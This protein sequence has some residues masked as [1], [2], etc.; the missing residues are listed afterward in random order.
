M[1]IGIDMGTTRTIAAGVD[2]GN[3]PV[4]PFTDPDGD[5]HSHFPSVIA[6]ADGQLVHGFEAERA[7]RAGAPHL[8]SFKRLLGD[9]DTHPGTT[10]RLG[11][12]EHLLLDLVTAYLT[13]VREALPVPVGQVAASV[14]AHA[15]SAQRIMTLE[16]FR[17]AGIDV[18]AL[19]NEPSAAG[20]EYTHHQSR[21][22]TARRTRIAVYD[23]GGGTFDSSLVEADG[24][25]HTVL[26]S[27]GVNRLGG[28]DLDQVLLELVLERAGLT[29]EELGAPAVDALREEC[30]AAKERLLPQT[31][32]MMIDLGEEHD[33][34]I[35]P[36]EDFYAAVAPL[37]ERTLEV[38]ARWWASSMRSPASPGSISSAAGP[39]CRWWDGCCASASAAACTAPRTRR[40]PPRSASRSPRTQTPGSPSPTGSPAASACSARSGR[41]RGSPSTRS[42]PPT[43]PCRPPAPPP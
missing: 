36:V 26:G 6:E 33:P 17:R 32:R 42:S 24:G 31:R 13:A 1:R 5:E 7:A 41:G 25:E 29:V 28:D 23:L 12:R 9:P 39:V 14:P 35:L 30:R 15:H 37:I 43:R 4:L 11:G 10:V 34:V 20:F 22:L 8:R 27:H 18:V 38:M 40:P 16:A 21:S 3:Y 19:L 2:R